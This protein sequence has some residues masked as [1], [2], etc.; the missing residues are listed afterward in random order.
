[1]NLLKEKHKVIKIIVDF[2]NYVDYEKM[3]PSFTIPKFLCTTAVAQ[4]GF[5]PYNMDDDEEEEDIMYEV[6]GRWLGR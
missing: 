4:H 1:M 2:E 6:W 5:S 3:Q